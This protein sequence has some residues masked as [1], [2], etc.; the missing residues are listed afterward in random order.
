MLYTKGLFAIFC[1]SLL[2]MLLNRAAFITI[3]NHRISQIRHFY[4]LFFF[5][6]SRLMPGLGIS[7]PILMEYINSSGI[8]LL[9]TS[10]IVQ[11][12]ITQRKIIISIFFC[13][14]FKSHL[15]IKYN[16]VWC[17]LHLFA[18][19]IPIIMKCIRK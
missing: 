18:R 9:E 16:W 12:R 13:L 10:K 19:T 6:D 5:E 1:N 14:N 7:S 2:L 8:S 15:F 11:I 3:K 4:L 17:L